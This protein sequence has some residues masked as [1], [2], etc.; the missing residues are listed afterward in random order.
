MLPFLPK[1]AQYKPDSLGVSVGIS[2]EVSLSRRT[3]SPPCRS[4]LD[5]SRSKLILGI[6]LPS[7]G[8]RFHHAA[9]A[10]KYSDQSRPGHSASP[11]KKPFSVLKV[12]SEHER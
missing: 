10:Q 9:R 5:L 11:K 2:P 3:P 6:T 12:I 7:I 4:K 8:V 1:V